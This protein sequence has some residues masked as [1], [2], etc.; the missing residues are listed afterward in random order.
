VRRDKGE[1]FSTRAD[2]IQAAATIWAN[3]WLS[4]ETTEES[5]A[6]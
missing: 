6:A 2:A 4:T 3:Y 5:V 1:Y